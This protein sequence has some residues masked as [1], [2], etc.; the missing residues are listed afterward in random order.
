MLPGLDT[1]NP[2][3]GGKKST[4]TRLRNHSKTNRHLI[5][6]ESLNSSEHKIKIDTSSMAESDKQN[7]ESFKVA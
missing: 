5:S 7:K 3:R 6:Y 4:R 2:N 1:P